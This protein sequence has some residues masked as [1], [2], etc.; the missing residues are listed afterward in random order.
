MDTTRYIAEAL[1]KL[2]YE[3]IRVGFGGTQSGV[4]AD[5]VGAKG[6]KCVALR[7]DIDA[8]PLND[9]KDVPYKSQK[10]NAM[11]AC[12]HDAHTSM[13][14]GAAKVLVEIQP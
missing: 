12:G 14:L 11:H 1:K 7:A 6:D 8:L 2:G 3:N 13:L 4:I 5:I 9:E 10:E